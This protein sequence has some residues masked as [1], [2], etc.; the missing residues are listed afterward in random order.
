MI[1]DRLNLIEIIGR[2]ATIRLANEFAGTRLYVPLRPKPSQEL[3]VAIGEDAMQ[4]LVARLGGSTI[5][6]PLYRELRAQFYRAQGLS[7]ARI[8]ARLGVT[9]GGVNKIFRRVKDHVDAGGE[10]KASPHS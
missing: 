9:E 7:N 1:D 2:D 8:A 10:M 3:T 4:A 5:R 6:V